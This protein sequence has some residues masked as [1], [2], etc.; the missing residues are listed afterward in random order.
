MPDGTAKFLQIPTWDR[1][2]QPS[3]STERLVVVCSY[4][5][6]IE[7][8]RGRSGIL[9]APTI[10]ITNRDPRLADIMASGTPKDDLGGGLAFTHLNL[11]PFPLTALNDSGELNVVADLSAMT[12]LGPAPLAIKQLAG[13]KK[14]ELTENARK[15]F[16]TKLAVFLGR[17]DM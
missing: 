4:D 15:D 6:D 1:V 2:A 14:F 5:C 11:F 7:N 8:P 10:A 3:D 17:P 12:S 9:I 13:S 16:R